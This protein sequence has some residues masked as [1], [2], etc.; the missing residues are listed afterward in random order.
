MGTLRAGRILAAVVTVAALVAGCGASSNRSA[1]SSVE[2][3]KSATRG[4]G[5]AASTSGRL[6]AG[7]AGG[8]RALPP[9]GRPPV[10][11]R[12]IVYTAA[13]TVRARNVAAAAAQAQSIATGAGGYVFS[14]GTVV[15]PAGG[16]A[17]SADVVL[18]VPPGSFSTVLRSLL[19]LGTSLGSSQHVDDVTDQVVDVAAR[20]QSQQASVARVR[21]LLAQARTVGEVVA[22]ESELTMREADLES[23]LGRQR[24]LDAQVALSTITVRLVSPAAASVGPRSAPR[25]FLAGLRAGWHAFVRALVASLTVLGVLLPFIVTVGLLLLAG[26]PLRRLL[27]ARRQADAVRQ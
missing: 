15:D 8:P 12:S 18:K 1:G 5:G 11:D 9:L 10:A 22:V 24:A 19:G 14:S 17:T 21:A 6:S 2:N 4:Q 13:L 16:A 25:G 3:A 23:L 7:P 26:V 20:L 27:L